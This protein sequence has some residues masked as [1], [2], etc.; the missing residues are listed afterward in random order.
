MVGPEHRAVMLDDQRLRL[1]APLALD[2]PGDVEV[3]PDVD[4]V[5]LLVEAGLIANRSS[6]WAM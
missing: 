6:S 2:A 4:D 3:V 1:T 5:A